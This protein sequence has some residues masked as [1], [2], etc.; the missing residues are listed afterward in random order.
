M[1]WGVKEGTFKGQ[2]LER[3]SDLGDTIMFVEEMKSKDSHP[4]E[5]FLKQ[6]CSHEQSMHYTTKKIRVN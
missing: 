2:H 5:A 1:L 4:G 3:E 6:Q